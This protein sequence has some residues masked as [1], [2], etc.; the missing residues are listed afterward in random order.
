[1][2]PSE[3]EGGTGFPSVRLLRM[4]QSQNVTS[5]EFHM[6]RAVFAFALVDKSLSIEEQELLRA[7]LK[8]VPFS[9]MQRETLKNDFLRPQNVEVMYKQISEPEHKRRFCVLARAL[10]WC[11]GDLDRQEEEILRRVACMKGTNDEEMLRESRT[12]PNLRDFYQHYAKA[13]VAGLMKAGPGFE[14][15]V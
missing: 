13:G 14:M 7:H 12:H 3:D 11:E 8:T 5:S 9:P 15:R 4:A 2:V 10:A 1:M 6:W